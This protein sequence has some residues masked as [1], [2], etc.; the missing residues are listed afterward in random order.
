MIVGGGLHTPRRKFSRRR[1]HRRRKTH[2]GRLATIVLGCDHLHLQATV[3]AEEVA[4][5]LLRSEA[6]KSAQQAPE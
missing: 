1:I 6:Q 3:V 5:S 2:H 4:C